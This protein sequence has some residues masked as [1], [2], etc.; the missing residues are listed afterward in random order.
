MGPRTQFWCALRRAQKPGSS[1]LMIAGPSRSVLMIL[2]NYHELACVA[3]RSKAHQACARAEE[4]KNIDQCKIPCVCQPRGGKLGKPGSIQYDTIYY[5]LHRSG[6][7][8]QRPRGCVH[9]VYVFVG[10]CELGRS[11]VSQRCRFGAAR[12]SLRYC[13][14]TETVTLSDRDR[15]VTVLSCTDKKRLFVDNSQFF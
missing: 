9:D 6:C 12:V 10:A 14:V 13:H 4:S 15:G 2:D 7:A 1:F 3:A 5:P 11:R 8:S